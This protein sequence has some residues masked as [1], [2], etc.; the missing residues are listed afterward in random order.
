MV[1][2][3]P[4]NLVSRDDVSGALKIKTAGKSRSKDHCQRRK[5]IYCLLSKKNVEGVPIMQIVSSALRFVVTNQNMTGHSDAILYSRLAYQ[6]VR[7]HNARLFGDQTIMLDAAMSFEIE[8][9]FF[10]EIALV[11]VTVGDNKFIIGGFGACNDHS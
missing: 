9:G 5:L 2:W 7:E 6:S 3:C 11:E 8:D 4:K 1:F 10:H